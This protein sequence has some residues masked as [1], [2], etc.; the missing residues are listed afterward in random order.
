[1]ASGAAFK[2]KK[3]LVVRSTATIISIDNFQITTG[4]ITAY[5]TLNI[6][7]NSVN[8]IDSRILFTR[9]S[10][11]TYV[12]SDGLIKYSGKN[13]PR[14]DYSSTSTGT[15]L[16]LLIEQ[17]RTNY[18][19]YSTNIGNTSSWSLQ[20]GVANSAGYTQ[21][22]NICPDGTTN[23]T[24]LYHN[25][26]DI[27]Y[28]N[29]NTTLYLNT[30][31]SYASSI[32]VKPVN[33]EPTAQFVLFDSVSN[34]NAVNY[35]Y[36][37]SSDSF[38]YSTQ[39]TT[40]TIVSPPVREL[41]P[42]GWYRLS[43]SYYFNSGP[44]SRAITNNFQLDTS[45]AVIGRGLLLWGAQCEDNARQNTGSDYSTSLIPTGGA[46]VTRAQ[47]Q[48]LI[49]GSAFQPWFNPL[50]GT[51]YTEFDTRAIGTG[52]VAGENPGIFGI[53]NINDGTYNG[54]GAR[55][56]NNSIYPIEFASRRG[57]TSI[58]YAD[59]I[60]Y[61]AGISSNYIQANSLYK[62]AGT[63]GPS[64]NFTFSQNG[65]PTAS[66]SNGN[67]GYLVFNTLSIGNQNVGGNAVQLNGHIKRFSYW[68]SALSNTQLQSLTTTTTYVDTNFASSSIFTTHVAN[69]SNFV[70]KQGV[71]VNT[72]LEISD[73]DKYY[74]TNLKTPTQ[75]PGLNLNFLK[76][77]L[78]PR[79]AFT[80]ASG[81]TVVGSNGYI[82]Y[83]GNN[84]PRFDYS[85]TSTGT[86]LGLLME[87]SR[88]NLLLGST[89]FNNPTYWSTGGNVLVVPNAAI[90]PDGQLSA[91]KV[92]TSA[93]TA[94]FN[95][96]A[97]GLSVSTGTYIASVYAKAGEFNYLKLYMYDNTYGSVGDFFDLRTGASQGPVQV[98]STSTYAGNGWWRCSIQR[99]TT[100]TISTVYIC[101]QAFAFSQGIGDGV[102]GAY[103]WGPQLE[104]G[105]SATSYIPTGSSQVT[106]STEQA[107]ISGQ[108]FQNW[109]NNTQG[110][111]YLEAD[112]NVLIPETTPNTYRWAFGIFDSGGNDFIGMW[113]SPSGTAL[114]SRC[115]SPDKVYNFASYLTGTSGGIWNST[116]YTKAALSYK[117]GSQF[118]TANAGT[119]YSSSATGTVSNIP[120]PQGSYLT[121]GNGDYSWIGHIRRFV[122]YPEALATTIT[123]A[124]VI[125]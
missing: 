71:I 120:S 57:G 110:T 32:F 29:L 4:T 80:R 85:S 92:I 78:D 49:S 97:N 88:T 73:V 45:S 53:Y 9:A 89:Q 16:G 95:V 15:C 102:S 8:A 20:A 60:Y 62:I 119:T 81:A 55:I 94:F 74:I 101:S 103:I 111:I 79:I 100:G 41:Y 5:P 19:L 13:V 68:P 61:A 23:A 105:L 33:G 34:L 35:T 114:G 112:S 2:V 43:V 27:T 36:T 38:S 72:N 42:N 7:F 86:C 66:A 56:L 122:Y 118:I 12:G 28:K 26:T 18:I 59:S 39:G 44:S 47:D 48:A 52:T 40:A 123:Q 82:Q 64:G 125:I 50:Q 90:A 84:I 83:V 30:G 65:S 77:I 117:N 69:T 46:T 104:Q 10:G 22:A 99:T 76:G 75:Q 121:I 51:V 91:Y 96:Y 87:E 1:M 37:F 93:T 115:T 31:V 14:I 124:L 98:T 25:T 6:S 108:N 109:Y 106:R 11:A 70:V 58:Y 67:Y 116:S 63:Y 24:F 21:Y 107:I 54:Y 3:S 17:Q 113:K